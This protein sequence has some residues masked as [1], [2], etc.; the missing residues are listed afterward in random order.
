M[1]S[2]NTKQDDVS[3]LVDERSS[4]ADNVPAAT[5]MTESNPMPATDFAVT[6][7]EDVTAIP[8]PLSKCRSK[9]THSVSCIACQKKTVKITNLQRN[10]RRWRNRCKNLSK[11]EA[12]EVKK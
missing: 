6:Y 5:F 9:A 2:L 7:P 3:S 1:E 10:V 12:Q 8:S 4:Q 11:K